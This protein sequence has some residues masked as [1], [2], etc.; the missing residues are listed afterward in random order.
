MTNLLS[1]MT[2]LEKK[3]ESQISWQ[4]AKPGWGSSQ[5]G[6]GA[7]SDTTSSKPGWGK[8][9]DER[10]AAFRRCW[11]PYTHAIIAKK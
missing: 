4:A 8:N 3:M 6:L 7:S 5:R 11:A 2:E 10:S 1:E 9:S